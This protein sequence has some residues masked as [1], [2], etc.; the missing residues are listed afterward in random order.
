VLYICYLLEFAPVL[1]HRSRRVSVADPWELHP[2]VSQTLPSTTTPHP[3]YRVVA[4]SCSPPSE[5]VACGRLTRVCQR[6]LRP[7]SIPEIASDWR[8]CELYT[9]RVS[10]LCL[11]MRCLSWSCLSYR[12]DR[13]NRPY[14]HAPEDGRL[15]AD[16]PCDV[17]P[18]GFEEDD[19]RHRVCKRWRLTPGIPFLSFADTVLVSSSSSSAPSEG[20]AVS[21]VL[22]IGKLH[23]R[24]ASKSWHN[25]CATLQLQAYEDDSSHA[26]VLRCHSHTEK[27]RLRLL[28]L[29]LGL[30]S[31]VSAL[32]A[33]G[34]K[35]LVILDEE[36][37]KSKYS[38]FWTDLESELYRLHLALPSQC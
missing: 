29:L 37:E 4:A 13:P 34:N 30:L 23:L 38:Q 35:L 9:R 6:Y 17:L 31:I 24:R 32:S 27:M 2:T 22:R 10:R 20:G 7:R 11:P 14:N 5:A 26:T 25:Q 21:L 3:A 15:R 16:R 33:Q 12:H 1:N 8:D 28:G 18:R 19:G 36:A